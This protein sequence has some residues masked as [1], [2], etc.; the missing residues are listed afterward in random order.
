MITRNNETADACRESVVEKNGESQAVS[1]TLRVKMTLAYSKKEEGNFMKK[2]LAILLCLSMLLCFMPT[3]AFAEGT[4]TS[5]GGISKSKVAL[6][7][8]DSKYETDITLSLP[9][10]D[11]P[12]VS[13][14]VFVL[15]KSTSDQNEERIL[16]MLTELKNQVK[17]TS[18]K[19]NVGIVIFNKIANVELSLT[20]LNDQNFSEI[21]A[22]IK[23]ER[24]SGTN[25][26]AGL[27]AGKQM[28]EAGTAN[29]ERKYLILVSDGV[30]YLFCDGENYE[31]P[32]TR[33][34]G[35]AGVCGTL[36]E[37]TEF[38]WKDGYTAY[39]GRGSGKYLPKPAE[40]SP[41]FDWNAYFAYLGSDA[42]KSTAD[43]QYDVEYT[44]SDLVTKMPQEYGLTSNVEKALYLTNQVYQALN[45]Q[46]H[47]YA[48]DTE[49]YLDLY[50]W[51]SSFMNYLA[52]GETIDFTQIQNDIQY[53]IGAGSRIVDVMGN[54]DGY[55]FDFINNIDRLKLTVGGQELEKTVLNSNDENLTKYGFGKEIERNYNNETAKTY[56]YVLIY[57]KA[58]DQ[59][60][61]EIN[62]NV[63][64]FEPVELT[65][66]VKLMNPSSA[67]G[68][69]GNYDPDGSKNYKG[70]QTNSSAKLY[71]VDSTGRKGD[72]EEFAKPTVS[73]TVNGGSYNP[74]TTTYG[75]VKVV[76]T[77]SGVTLPAG[78]RVDVNF[79]GAAGM[80]T[81]SITSF[82]DNRGT[83][84]L[85]LQ[86]GTYTYTE[87]ATDI[88]GYQYTVQQGTVTVEAGKTAE[89]LLSN[90]YTQDAEQPT[91][92]DK[93]TKPEQPAKPEQP[94]EP[95]DKTEVPK[96]GDNSALAGSAL[97]LL[98]SAGGITA[99][100]RRKEE[101]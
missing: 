34:F 7:D 49:K 8:L 93:P 3:A 50:P 55:N 62:V 53:L 74:P 80:K 26:H 25:I 22:A 66:G 37:L 83:G 51:G 65:Y 60:D 11:T 38:Q 17:A 56:P 12:L 46:Y 68:T 9:A 5:E 94:T 31:T 32:L 85:T 54:V 63:S 61:L 2:V 28:L 70:L 33:S 27:V 88:D 40:F 23:T 78:Y 57:D 98:L 47:V 76:K 58:A 75:T 4:T 100:L 84:F 72:E 90:I 1:Q 44:G 36:S 89:I 91:T 73:Y 13:D 52:A 10:K 69:H 14:V 39:S 21:E 59:F 35:G 18:A 30:T 87:T 45:E 81:L 86:P 42:Q 97:L 82:A 95:E 64:Q 79:T 71:P 24:E 19:V 15:D 43:T 67:A 99:A 48:V 77:V 41:A 16:S 20:E 96:T 92:P 6:A 101:K 29:A